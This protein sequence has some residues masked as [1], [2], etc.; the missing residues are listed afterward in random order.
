MSKRVLITGI[1]GQDASYLKELLCLDGCE[2]HGT[3]R[4]QERVNSFTHF[5]DLSDS[6]S[7][8]KVISQV[9]PDEVYNLAAQTHVGTSFDY[10][11]LTLDVTGSGSIRIL[12]AIRKHNKDIKFYQASTSELFGDS[13]S[14]QNEKTPFRPRSPYGIAKQV[15][16]QAVINYRDAY[17]MWASNGILFNHE[18]PRR[19]PSFVTRKISLGAA[20]IKLGIQDNL[21]LGNLDAKRDWGYAPEYAQAMKMIMEYPE[22][23]DIVIATGVSYTVR[24]FASLC[25]SVLDLNW[26]EHVVISQG[27][28]RPSEVPDLRG[29]PS[30]A[31]EKLG[32]VAHTRTPR[33][34]EIMVKSDYDNQLRL[35]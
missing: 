10:P 16:Y 15:A 29:D 13:P 12:E 34:A 4:H 20:R 11:E 1:S 35:M 17:N 14:P 22:P 6:S 9:D 24:D 27:E 18:S 2:V 30:L 32:W 26:E 28:H 21:V 23:V 8:R 31:E 3:T 7:V 33:L 5:M 19:H 25:F